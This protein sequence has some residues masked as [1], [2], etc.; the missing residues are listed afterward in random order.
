MAGGEPGR[1]GTGGGRRHRQPAG[2]DRRVGPGHRGTDRLRA[3]AGRTCAPSAPA[4]SCRAGASGWRPTPRPPSWRPCWTRPTPTGRARVAASWPSAPSTPGWPGRSRRAGSTSPTPPT[5][6]SPA[7]SPPT[8]AGWDPRLLDALRDPRGPPPRDRR[9][10]RRRS[11]RPG[12]FPAPRPSPASPVTS[13]PPSSAR[14]APAPGRPRP[15]SGP[16]GCST[17]ASGPTRPGFAARGPAGTIPIIAWQRGSTPTW[18]IEAV[19]LSAGTCVEWLRDDLG[20]I[21]SAAD[22][23]EVAARCEDTGDV[24]FVPALLGLGTPGV[25]LRGPGDPPRRHPG[26]RPSRSWSGRCSRAWPTAGPTC[27]RRPSRTRGSTPAPSGSTGGCRPTRC[28]PRPWPRRAAGPSRSPR[29]SRRPPSGPPTSPAWRWA[30]GRGEDD[31]AAAWAPREVVEPE[32]PDG[33][34]A[35]RRARWLEARSRA[36]GTV[37]ELSAL[38]F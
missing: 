33:D 14:D 23:A 38:E 32:A 29:C 24:W 4:S 10:D 9:L 30:P 26:H 1:G 6:G 16:A 25:G 15:P 3:S 18:G 31:V 22:S 27:S 2:V 12:R 34:R 8:A 11:V 19:M 35:T 37:P 28:S 17:S 20:V 36:E 7:C 5:P 13:R 21:D